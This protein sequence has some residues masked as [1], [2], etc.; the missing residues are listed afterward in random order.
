M[1]PN[2]S[3]G[4]FFVSGMSLRDWF[5]GKALGNLAEHHNGSAMDPKA[6]AKASYRFADAMLKARGEVQ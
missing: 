2:E 5:A 6:L 4:K 3:E 1:G